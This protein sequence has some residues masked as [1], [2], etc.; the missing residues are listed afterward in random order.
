MTGAKGGIGM[1]F[2]SERLLR[3]FL[4]KLFLRVAPD[5]QIFFPGA[6][7]AETASTESYDGQT[8]TLFDAG[9]HEMLHEVCHHLLSSPER[10]EK[11]NWE[12]GGSPF[13]PKS[14]GSL[15]WSQQWAISQMR[16]Y[17]AVKYAIDEEIDTCRLEMALAKLLGCGYRRL[18][19]RMKDLSF[20][21]LPTTEDVSQLEQKYP[22][23]LSSEMWAQLKECHAK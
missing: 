6:N 3:E 17:S 9:K 14:W 7:P 2:R 18:R 11:V 12:L 20:K 21:T 22:D 15:S 8:L 23:A 10:R 1:S 13:E 16:D 4:R 19:A 5:K